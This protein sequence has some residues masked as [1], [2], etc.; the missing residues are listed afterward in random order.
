MDI[1]ETHFRMNK[2]LFGFSNKPTKKNKKKE[3]EYIFNFTLQTDGIWMFII[4][5]SLFGR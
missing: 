2:K 3:P 5:T 4:Q 1:W